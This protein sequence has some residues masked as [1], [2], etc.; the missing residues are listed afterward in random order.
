MC[1][2]YDISMNGVGGHLMEHF[3]YLWLDES[4]FI[5]I[6]SEATNSG[7]DLPFNTIRVRTCKNI[8]LVL[9]KYTIL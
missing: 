5:K 6:P 9:T 2:S 8:Y 7:K 1:I 3:E 4:R